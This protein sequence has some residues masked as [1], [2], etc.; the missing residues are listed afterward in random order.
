MLKMVNKYIDE[1]KKLLTEKSD[2]KKQKNDQQYQDNGENEEED[3][4]ELIENQMHEYEEYS[5]KHH[6]EPTIELSND[7]LSYERFYPGRILGNTF[8][9]INKTNQ[10][11]IINLSFTTDGL[12]KEFVTQ[13]LL[14]YNEIEQPYINHLKKEF[15]DSEKEFECWYIEDPYK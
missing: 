10:A 15:I 4:E 13:K 1:I 5:S 3:D 14:E 8:T 9:I 11:M 7:I 12:D 6:F 2:K